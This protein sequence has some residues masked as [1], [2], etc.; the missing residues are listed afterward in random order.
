MNNT[1]TD[2]F[3]NKWP[4]DLPREF[5]SCDVCWTCDS[6]DFAKNMCMHERMEIEDPAFNRCL[7]FVPRDD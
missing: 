7:A 4:Y 2:T 5:Y 1:V 3:I 6:Y